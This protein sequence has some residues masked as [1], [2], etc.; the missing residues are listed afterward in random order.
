MFTTTADSI[1]PSAWQGYRP[2]L[3]PL[4]ASTLFGKT[5]RWWRKKGLFEL[6][7]QMLGKHE[8][9]VKRRLNE[10][11]E[12]CAVCLGGDLKSLKCPA[13]RRLREELD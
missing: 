11:H 3:D 10:H 7:Q 6:A 12:A 1:I 8:R 5:M 13:R 9:M 2:P 4:D